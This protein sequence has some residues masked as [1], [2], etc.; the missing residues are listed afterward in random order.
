ML[1]ARTYVCVCARARACGRAGATKKPEAILWARSHRCFFHGPKHI[2]HCLSVAQTSRVKI[3]P[4]AHSLAPSQQLPCNH[5][6][7]H[8]VQFW[9]RLFWFQ[10]IEC[11]LSSIRGQFSPRA[12]LTCLSL[13][14]AAL[15]CLAICRMSSTKSYLAAAAW[16]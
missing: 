6:A 13:N 14:S 7:I 15:V 10:L 16:L 12:Y 5:P 4:A 8:K 2:F 9:N 3:R 11:I 1:C